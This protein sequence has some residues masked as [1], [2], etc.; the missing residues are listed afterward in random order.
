MKVKP[1]ESR[2]QEGQ[3]PEG[4]KEQ[5]LGDKPPTGCSDKQELEMHSKQFQSTQNPS[6][7]ADAASAL[8]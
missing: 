8:R 1:A 2:L 7:A 5:G 3:S 4:D 6:R